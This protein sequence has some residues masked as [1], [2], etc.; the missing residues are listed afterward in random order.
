MRPPLPKLLT[1]PIGELLVER[2]AGVSLATVRVR[3]PAAA[4][5]S[6]IALFSEEGPEPGPE[7]GP[8]PGREPFLE[9]AGRGDVGQGES[10]SES[11]PSDDAPTRG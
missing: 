6:A 5:P 8:E 1:V 4:E 3:A 2:A 11:L 7:T 9:E 10:K